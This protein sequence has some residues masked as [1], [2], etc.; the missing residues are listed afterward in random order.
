VNVKPILVLLLL[1]LAT[2]MLALLPPAQDPE[3]GEWDAAVE[4]ACTSR[5][6]G[7][8]LAA[9]RRV[10]QAGAAAVP[11]I[12]AWSDKHGADSLPAELV[13]AI[14]RQQTAD[15]AVADQLQAWATDRVFYWRA[16][17]FLGLADRAPLLPARRDE[18][19][20][21]FSTYRDD[22]AWLVRT[23]SR[24]GLWLLDAGDRS[25]RDDDDPRIASK[26]AA[27]RLARGQV[28]ELQPLLD[29]LAD[30]RTFQ[31]VDWG[32]QRALEAHAALRGALGDEHPLAGGAAADDKLAAIAAVRDAIARKW[33]Q[34]LAVPALRGDAAT[35]FQG[36]IAVQSCRNGDLYLQWTADGQLFGGLEAAPL[37]ALPASA[38]DALQRDRTALQ[39]GA[40]LGVLI[41]D[42]LR[43][44]W[45][46]P[47]TN[48][49]VAPESLPAPAADWL[50]QL[51]RTLRAADKPH[52]ADALLAT[53]DQFAAR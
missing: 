11:A 46:E 35:P 50:A 36:G 38:W 14:A 25:A 53:I 15:A 3:Q 29:A 27:L 26:L 6:Y 52:H 7:L 2:P 13:D 19:V 17:A 24:L 18:F 43:L 45:P 22:P 4:K 23:Y 37:V 33:G 49:L 47:A 31:G 34:Q 5:R 10:A 28:P 32:P 9:A 16:N 30:E 42:N 51:A 39:L 40:S 1:A 20:A 44:C 12:R 48:A 8:R 41:C 21:L